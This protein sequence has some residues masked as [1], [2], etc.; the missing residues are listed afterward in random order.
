MLDWAAGLAHVRLAGTVRP[1]DEGIRPAL[2][3]LREAIPLQ[4][5]WVLYDGFLELRRAGMTGLNEQLVRERLVLDWVEA[6]AGSRS[7][8]D[9]HADR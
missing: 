7:G 5:L 8:A 6:A 2:E 4:A 3:A 9:A 1:G